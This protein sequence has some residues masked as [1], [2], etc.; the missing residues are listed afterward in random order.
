MN[1]AKGRADRGGAGVTYSWWHRNAEGQ[2]VM[3]VESRLDIPKARQRAS[4]QA[5]ANQQHQRHGHFDYDEHALCEVPRAAGA[6]SA[7]L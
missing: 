2:N 3:S 5:G 4:H 6:A 7:L 1:I